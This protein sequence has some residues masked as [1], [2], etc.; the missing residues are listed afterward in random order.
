MTLVVALLLVAVC[1]SPLVQ[2]S[3]DLQLE[4][5]IPLPTSFIASESSAASQGSAFL[6]DSVDVAALA[7][8][9]SA[10]VAQAEASAAAALESTSEAEAEA[11][12]DAE[13]SSSA[14]TEAHA[15]V[16]APLKNI[17]AL[18][19]ST[20][21]SLSKLFTLS[22]ATRAQLA[23]EERAVMGAGCGAG[24]CP[25]KHTPA[26]K[27]VKG[28]GSS[29]LSCFAPKLKLPE[30]GT[31]PYAL[32]KSERERVDRIQKH[33]VAIL[34]LLD[35]RGEFYDFSYV[36]NRSLLQAFYKVKRAAK[37]LLDDYELRTGA[38]TIAP[39]L[40]EPVEFKRVAANAVATPG[41]VP[42]SGPH[43]GKRRIP[44]PAGIV[45]LRVS[46]K[47]K[48]GKAHVSVD[49]LP[50]K[51]SWRTR[52]VG[53]FGENP[54]APVQVSVKSIAEHG[55]VKADGSPA[56]S[57][58]ASKLKNYPRFSKLRGGSGSGVDVTS[59]TPEQ[60][61]ALPPAQLREHLYTLQA[62]AQNEIEAKRSADLHAMQEE[63]HRALEALL[64]KKQ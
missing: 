10:A 48:G 3:A 43:S 29:D 44:G 50:A 58:A 15:A 45:T 13:L 21:T 62:Q 6:S 34:Q 60:L 16:M 31:D 51:D 46:H 42:F 54:N 33:T 39:Y 5:D 20:E 30:L 47:K 24:G 38:R 63:M 40:E 23:A 36:K 59:M 17:A 37:K 32:T 18:L 12:A 25:H 19:Q 57:T 56:P 52:K 64:P 26:G 22:G 8:E 35:M 9:S 61:R 1:A 55:I 53:E 27:K 4:A 28:C 41:D 7:E 14:S 49:M 11:G 2:A